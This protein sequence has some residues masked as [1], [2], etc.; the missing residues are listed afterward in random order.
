M[1]GSVTLRPEDFVLYSYCN[2][3]KQHVHGT[4]GPRSPVNDNT[5]IVKYEAYKESIHMTVF[6]VV[7]Q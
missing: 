5:V 1:S 6:M 2:W 3:S 7:L 4:D